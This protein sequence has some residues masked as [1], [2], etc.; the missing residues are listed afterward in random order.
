MSC[1][2]KVGTESIF[3]KPLPTLTTFSIFCGYLVF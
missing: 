2:I 1:K 3:R